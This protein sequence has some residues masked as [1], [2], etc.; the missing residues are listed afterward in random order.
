MVESEGPLGAPRPLG[1][2][3]LSRDNREPTVNNIFKQQSEIDGGNIILITLYSR[4]TMGS[5]NITSF[6]GQEYGRDNF[7]VLVE[8]SGETYSDEAYN[9]N[10]TGAGAVVELTNSSVF[11]STTVMESDISSYYEMEEGI[12]VTASVYE[13]AK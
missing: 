4:M 12:N 7:E 1:I 8:F 3:P 11:P 13:I 6:L 2:T 9:E 10:Y 5:D